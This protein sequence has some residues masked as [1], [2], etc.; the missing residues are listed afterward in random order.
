MNLQDYIQRIKLWINKQYFIIRHYRIV[1][2]IFLVIALGLIT[3]GIFYPS[4]EEKVQIQS[5][6]F[7]D[8]ASEQRLEISKDQTEDTFTKRNNSKYKG[9]S[10]IDGVDH[11]PISKRSDDSNGKGRLLYDVSSVERPHPWREVF[12]DI[13]S[14]DLLSQSDEMKDMDNDLDTISNDE[15][16]LSDSKKISN[17]RTSRRHRS[18]KNKNIKTDRKNK[19]W[20]SNMIHDDI[21]NYSNESVHSRTSI[22]SNALTL[23][24]PIELVGIIEGNQNIAIL[25]KGSEEQMVTVGSSWQGISVSNI[26]ASGVEI[27][28]GGSSR[29]LKIE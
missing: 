9:K 29:W 12:K 15:T 14:T 28:E 10:S 7:N 18:S 13:S 3:V 1:I 2:I 17:K 21:N 6:Q 20:N 26:T 27:I 23:E 22:N 11:K 19:D 25:R 5:G 8:Q 24:Q 4:Q 16:S